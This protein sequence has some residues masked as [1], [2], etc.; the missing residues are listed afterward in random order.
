MGN[1]RA[2]GVVWTSPLVAALGASLTIPLAMVGDMLLH[3]RHYSLVYIFGSLQV[4]NQKCP[5]PI[6]IALYS[7]DFGLIS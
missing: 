4:S 3:G 7:V 6:P 1:F 2:M 5:I